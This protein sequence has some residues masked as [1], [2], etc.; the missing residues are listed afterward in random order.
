MADEKDQEV[1]QRLYNTD[2]EVR[3]VVQRSIKKANPAAVFPELDVE[4]AVE[5]VKKTFGEQLEETNGR[6]Q[7]TNAE[8][9]REKKH[10]EWRAKGLDPELLEKTIETYGLTGSK[11]LPVEQA[12]MRII[13]AEA[14]TA[15]GENLNVREQGR[16]RMADDWKGLANKSDATINAHAQ[17][18]AHKAVDEIINANR[19]SQRGFQP[20]PLRQF[21]KR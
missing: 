9:A 3:R 15:A 1:L 7:R 17:D 11:E 16:M 4:D 19:L 6:L 21:M 13:E 8:L 12:A 18:E 2:P 14:N 10:T 5:G 20:T